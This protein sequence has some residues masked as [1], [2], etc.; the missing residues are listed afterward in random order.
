M[1]ESVLQSVKQMLGI[2]KDCT[3]FDQILIMHI[4]SV[5]GA[6]NQI[7]F[8]TGL[9]EDTNTTWV[10]VYQPSY[11]APFTMIKSYMYLKVK[12]LFDPPTNSAVIE[13]MNRQISEFEWR[14]NIACESEL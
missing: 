1:E 6:L 11:N 13:A 5:L 4:N 14:L 2:D 7:T 3:D 10:R 8:I 9:I 12:L